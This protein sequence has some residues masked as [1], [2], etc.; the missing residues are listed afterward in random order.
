MEIFFKNS[1]EFHY[2]TWSC[3]LFAKKDTI[4]IFPLG[5][6][7]NWAYMQYLDVNWPSEEVMCKAS[8]LK[9]GRKCYLNYIKDNKITVHTER[10]KNVMQ[11]F[12]IFERLTR[13]W[14]WQLMTERTKTIIYKILK[15]TLTF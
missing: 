13:Q 5:F 2:L 10:T 9:K 11:V 4:G 3:Y 15:N 7:V 6:W 14:R 8:H 12:K 1:S